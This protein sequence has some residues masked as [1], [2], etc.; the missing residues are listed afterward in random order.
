MHH[1]VDRY[2]KKSE[3]HCELDISISLDMIY[4]M[5]YL[6]LDSNSLQGTQYSLFNQSFIGS[7]QQCKQLENLH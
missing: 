3:E 2:H 1:K 7:T 6:V 4:Q 5:S